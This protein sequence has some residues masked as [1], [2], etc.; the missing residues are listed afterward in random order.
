MANL[1]LS[2]GR[3]KDSSDLNLYISIDGAD[4][5]ACAPFPV[6]KKNLTYLQIQRTGG[7]EEGRD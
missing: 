3:L 7:S 2:G 4:W 6:Q 5:K 1:V